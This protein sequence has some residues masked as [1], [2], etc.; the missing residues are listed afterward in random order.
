MKG[1]CLSKIN[2]QVLLANTFSRFILT[3][4]KEGKSF[5]FLI[6]VRG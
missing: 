1:D 6:K 3:K 2:F 4:N 5:K